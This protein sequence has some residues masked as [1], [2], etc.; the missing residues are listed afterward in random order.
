MAQDFDTF[1]LKYPELVSDGDANQAG[2]EECIADSI[3]LLGILASCL[4]LADN[5][6]LAHA[7]H[8]VAKSGHNPNGM[9]D[10]PGAVSN[11]SVG[12]VS[13]GYQAN[14]AIQKGG[15]LS[16]YYASTHYGRQ[17]QVLIRHCKGSGAMVVP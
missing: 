17:Y 4:K 12:S 9:D 3:I 14:A 6:I 1:K 13:V 8:C 5:I 16:S 11:T 7:A 10:S 2:I 15:N